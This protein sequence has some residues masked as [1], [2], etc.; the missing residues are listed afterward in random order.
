[1]KEYKIDSEKRSEGNPIKKDLIYFSDA[2]GEPRINGKPAD[3]ADLPK[4]LITAK[5]ELWSNRF[6]SLC[7]LA[8]YKDEYG[9]VLVNE[10]D[11]VTAANEN[12][13]MNGLYGIMI[14]RILDME[15]SPAF[16]EMSLLAGQWTG[17]GDC[18]E[19]IL[20]IPWNVQK[21]RM[22]RAVRIF[23]NIYSATEKE[24]VALAVRKVSE[25]AVLP[26]KD[27]NGAP[28][29]SIQA[30]ISEPVEIKPGALVSLETGI[31]VRIPEGCIGEVHARGKL[32][33]GKDLRSLDTI[34]GGRDFVPLRIVLENCS[35]ETQ[36]VLPGEKLARLVIQ[37]CVVAELAV[38]E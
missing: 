23:D 10:F 22:E 28:W 33:T 25:T 6:L 31:E 4:E 38:E 2:L 16:S 29:F 21:T 35:K 36:K 26:E 34:I 13:D 5:K 32:A 14:K 1:M 12:T 7:Y 11:P 20:F 3:I 27:P 18:H 24:T 17:F 30:D 9:I 37:Q 8:K 15:Q 19:A